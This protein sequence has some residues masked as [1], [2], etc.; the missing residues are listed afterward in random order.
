MSDEHQTAKPERKYVLEVTA[1]EAGALMGA[2]MR[3]PPLVQGLLARVIQQLTQ[4]KR[5][6]EAEA[7]VIKQ[8]GSDGTVVMTDRAGTTIIRP[9]QLWDEETD[10]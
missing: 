4:L 10:R 9:K 7:G 3:L 6:F 2:I 8:I 1:L 5:A